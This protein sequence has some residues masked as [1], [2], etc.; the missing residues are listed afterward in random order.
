[1]L[2]PNMPKLSVSVDYATANPRQANAQ[3]FKSFRGSEKQYIRKVQPV[4]K[5][6]F[7]DDQ[8]MLP[9]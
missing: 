1:M 7:L 2:C 3:D 5:E 4:G 9:H 8:L 6:S